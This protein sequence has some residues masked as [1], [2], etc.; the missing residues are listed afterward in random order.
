MLTLTPA[1]RRFLRS[2]AHTLHPVVMI[3]DSGLSEPVMKEL[4]RSVNSHELVKIK[5]SGSDRSARE[6]MLQQICNQL[7]VAPVQHIGKILVVYKPAE[8][9]KLV[10]PKES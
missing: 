8:K 1:Q 7:N 4:E 2:Q 5:V 3:G 9:P 6:L 10:L